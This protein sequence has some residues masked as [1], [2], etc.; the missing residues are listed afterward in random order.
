MTRHTAFLAELITTLSI[1]RR[2][3]VS[4]PLD[5]SAFTR[6]IP[7]VLLRPVF[8]QGACRAMQRAEL[9]RVLARG[10]V[11]NDLVDDHRDFDRCSSIG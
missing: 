8:L 5:L 11:S 6:K 4:F 7:R 10:L 2:S 9:C 3:L 1:R